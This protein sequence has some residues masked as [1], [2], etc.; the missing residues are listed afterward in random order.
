MRILVTGAARAIGRA[1]AVECARRG[2]EVVATARDDRL[3]E[4]LDV[5]KRLALDVTDLASVRAAVSAA[6]ELDAVVNN[7][8]LSGAGPLED[9][10][11]DRLQLI[12]DTN[13]Y[14]AL[15]VV[16]ELVPAW[17]ERGSGVIVNVSSVQGRVSTPLEGAYAASKYALEALSET[18]HYEL[19]HFGIRVVIVE[20]GYIAPG[21]KASPRHDGPAA[22]AELWDQWTGT[23][24]KLTGPTGRPGPEL[25][26]VAIA[27]AIE[28]PTTPLRVPVGADAEMVLGAR[29]HFDD[30]AFEAAMRKTLDLQW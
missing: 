1:T 20:P 16:Q 18:L 19:A 7:A 12:M 4:D 30:A 2:H 17:R 10:P 9:F 25:V 15:R 24:A 14:G 11:M 8:A 6:G 27:D 5:A 29:Q 28:N 26:G 22:Y 21:M 13:T 23:D 3:L